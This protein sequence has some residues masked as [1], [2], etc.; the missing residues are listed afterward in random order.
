MPLASLRC[1]SARFDDKTL[2]QKLKIATLKNSSIVEK[3]N[4]QFFTGRI[5]RKEMSTQPKRVTCFR[6]FLPCLGA[7]IKRG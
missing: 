1:R 2:N 3:K 4:M 7:K 5:K 6:E